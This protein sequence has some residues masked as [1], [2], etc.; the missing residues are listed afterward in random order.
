MLI[1]NDSCE[2]TIE[3]ADVSTKCPACGKHSTFNIITDCRDVKYEKIK[4]ANY[5][6]YGQRVCPQKDCKKH[7]FFI[8]DTLK[9]PDG[10]IMEHLQIYPEKA[11]LPE[12]DYKSIPKKI[13]GALTESIT[14]LEKECYIASAIMIRKTLEE[15]CHDKGAI[16]DN[17]HQRINN[18][19]D[20]ITISND[21]YDGLFELK[22]L[23][24]DAA[25]IESTHFSEVGKNEVQLG[26]SLTI[27]ILQ[28]L[29][30]DGKILEKF[31]SL[32]KQVV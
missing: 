7:I 26:L 14:C 23:G 25:H 5:L 13:K 10:Q 22:Y 3:Y 24:N 21:L 20:K 29:Y 27:R 18:L 15:I 30:E 9:I 32:K 28:S 8:L 16:G 12:L 6:Y 19:K 17:L 1:K 11:D 4:N 31:R 2:I